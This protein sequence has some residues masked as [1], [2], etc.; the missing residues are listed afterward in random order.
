MRGLFP[1]VV[2]VAGSQPVRTRLERQF[3]GIDIKWEGDGTFD[4]FIGKQS[5]G[6]FQGSK[7]RS[8][9]DHWKPKDQREKT[10]PTLWF[11]RYMPPFISYH[12]ASRMG[13]S[14]LIGRTG[15]TIEDSLVREVLAKG[16]KAL[17]TAWLRER[18]KDYE[19]LC[20]PAQYSRLTSL[21]RAQ[22]WIA[23][24]LL[25]HA[26]RR[27]INHCACCQRY[28]WERLPTFDYCFAV[29]TGAG[30]DVIQT[31]WLAYRCTEER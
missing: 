22:P 28:D 26:N 27:K 24:N 21:P 5:K 30:Q 11:D 17:I 2:T 31:D 20:E 10:T 9:I 25:M 16:A 6:F 1:I 18:P 4:D 3:R 8:E 15:Q 23:I 13:W 19:L 7:N 12:L 29:V 14:I